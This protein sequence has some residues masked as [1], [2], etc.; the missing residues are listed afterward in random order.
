MRYFIEYVTTYS[1]TGKSRK[2]ALLQAAVRKFEHMELADEAALLE[3]ARQLRRLVEAC[4]AVHRGKPITLEHSRNSGHI[5]ARAD[6]TGND[7]YVFSIGYAPVGGTLSSEN[8]ARQLW[9]PI[10]NVDRAVHLANSNNI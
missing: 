4:N 5:F 2:C 3:F 10:H 7:T 6:Q 1:V 9:D 8:I